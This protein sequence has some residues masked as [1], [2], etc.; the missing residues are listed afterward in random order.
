MQISLNNSKTRSQVYFE[1]LF[2][3]K[4]IDSKH[5]YLLP[6]QL[7]VITNL[8][9]FQYKILNNVL[10]LNEELFSFKKIPCSLCS[11]CQSENETPV[12][13]SHGYNHFFLIFKH[14]LFNSRE[15]KKLSIE[16]LKKEIVKIYNIEK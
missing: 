10:Y 3:N 13:L 8:R 4:Y 14:Y 2:Q 6:R 5:V 16:V 12:H 9:I 7:T 11:F 15:Y 1:D